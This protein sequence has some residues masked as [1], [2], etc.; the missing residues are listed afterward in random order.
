MHLE[1]RKRINYCNK[2]GITVQKNHHGKFFIE[3]VIYFSNKV[4]Y[5][6]LLGDK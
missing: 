4:F 6:T 1:T 3:L 5:I 2:F